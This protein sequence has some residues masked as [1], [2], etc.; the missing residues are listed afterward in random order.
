MGRSLRTQLMVETKDP[1][2]NIRKRPQLQGQLE[3]A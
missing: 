1:L 3:Y 2:G